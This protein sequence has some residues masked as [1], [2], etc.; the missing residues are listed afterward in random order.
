MVTHTRMSFIKRCLLGFL[1]LGLT[2]TSAV[3]TNLILSKD[4]IEAI[5]REYGLKTEDRVRAWQGLI[6]NHQ[7]EPEL[8]KLKLVNRFFNRIEYMHDQDLWGKRNYWATPLEF[9]I[10]NGGDCEDYALSKYFTLRAMGVSANKM[11]ITFVKSLKMD[12]A[13]M[14][15]SYYETPSEDPFV[16]DNTT[17]MIFYG[18]ERP[19]LK[20]IYSFNGDGVWVTD[21]P[22][23]A[24]SN[25]AMPASN[26]DNRML[27]WIDL[28]QRMM[29]Q[30]LL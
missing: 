26:G 20:P 27:L 17:D 30:G 23:S 21:K 13:H 11:R 8:V 28:K 15:L 12:R 14:V 3:A 4:R 22:L 1:L 10:R 6:K 19:D 29:A 9:I 18:T 25:T 24:G 5:G 7:H 2:G 16:L